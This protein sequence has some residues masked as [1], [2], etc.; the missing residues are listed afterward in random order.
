MSIKTKVAAGL[1]GVA[2]L[3]PTFADKTVEDFGD[4]P[5]RLS[6]ATVLGKP[7]KADLSVL[8]AA[9]LGDTIGARAAAD[10]IPVK[11]GTPAHTGGG[12]NGGMRP[13]SLL[14]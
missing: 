13:E 9:F 11:H 4:T 2:S 7:A 3:G 14:G 8:K 5:A 12:L 6:F 10:H 1:L